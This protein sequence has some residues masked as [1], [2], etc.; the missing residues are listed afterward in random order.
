MLSALLE[1]TMPIARKYAGP[2]EYFSHKVRIG[3]P[4]ECWEW[5]GSVGG[6]GYGNWC[7]AVN[8]LPKI[9]TAH[10]RAYIFFNGD[11]SGLQVNHRCGN[12]RCCNPNHLYAGT[13]KQNHEDSVKHETHV[14]PPYKK[15]EAVGTSK[16]TEEQVIKI[17][18]DLKKG[19]KGADI[20]KKYNVTTG[21]ISMIN[22]SKNWSWIKLPQNNS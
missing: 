13:Q 5:K 22:K 11:C 12:R 7:H 8:N 9:G 18:L 17:K 4:N 14:K 21:C 3:K 20:A 16:L 15:G 6:P 10:R 1:N 19:V 2:Y